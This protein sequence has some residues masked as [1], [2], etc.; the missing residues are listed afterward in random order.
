MGKSWGQSG[1]ENRF[2]IG[3]YGYGRPSSGINNL[4]VKCENNTYTFNTT[5]YDVQPSG[6][7]YHEHFNVIP[8]QFTFNTQCGATTIAYLRGAMDT[9]GTA[10]F[11]LSCGINIYCEFSVEGPAII[12][13]ITFVEN[14]KEINVN[15][16]CP[17]AII[18]IDI[19]DHGV[20]SGFDIECKNT[21][22]NWTKISSGERGEYSVSFNVSDLQAIGI[23]PFQ[24]FSIRTKRRLVPNNDYSTST[25][26][27]A[28][29]Y[30]PQFSFPAGKE[31]I[32]EPTKCQNGKTTIKIPYEGS[33]NYTI[34]IINNSNGT[35]EL[36][37]TT[38]SLTTETINGTKYYV[39]NATLLS[40]EHTLKIE[41]TTNGCYFETTFKVTEA[42]PFVIN[43]FT[44]PDKTG[45]YEI[46]TS[47][48]KGKVTF[49]IS[50]S[51][52]QNITIKAGTESFSKT[53]S[54]STET[55]GRTYYR[56]SVTIELPA[57]TYNI[58]A[59]NTAGCTSNTQQNVVLR[60]PNAI[61]FGITTSTPKCYDEKGNVT[62]KNI[63]GGIGA[64]TY[65]IGNGEAQ[66]FNTATVEINDLSPGT[67]SITIEDGYQNTKTENF[68]IASAPST[69]T[70]TTVITA[71][72]IFG[73]TDGKITLTA[74]GGTTPYT[75]SKNN[76]SGYQ[77]SNVLT[78]FS[79]GSKTVFVK[80]AN[81]CV[82]PFNTTIPEGRQ[83]TIISTTPTAPAC[84]GGTDGS[85]TL[86]IGNPK[87]TL[88]VAANY[89]LEYTVNGNSI[90]FRNLQ[91]DTYT[92]TITETYNGQQ[93]SIS[94][95]FTIPEKPI[96]STI[97]TVTPVSNKGTASGKI[98][99]SVSGGNAG[100]YRVELYE[101]NTKLR[102]Q[103][104][105][106]ACTFEN[107]TGEAVNGGKLYTLKIYDSRDCFDTKEVRILEPET[108]LI[109][110]ADIASPI[111]C[112]NA[113][114]AQIKITATGGWNGFLYSADSTVWNT[115]TTFGNLPAGIYK[116]FV[117]DKNGGTA[118]ATL[119]V[120]NP[121]PLLVETNTVK[122]AL[123]YGSATGAL[124]FKVSGG[125]YPYTLTPSTG[126][127]TE[128]ITASDTLITINDLPANNYTFTVRDSKNCST[129]ATQETITQPTKLELPTPR[130]IHTTCESPNGI[131]KVLAS[132]G[133][134]SYT[135]ILS[136][137][138]DPLFIPPLPQVSNALDTVSF[139]NLAAGVYQIKVTDNNACSTL[140]ADLI[141]NTYTN[142]SISGVTVDSVK[143]FGES[144][145]R[146]KVT[147]VNTSTQSIQTYFLYNNDN[148]L[149]Q[150]NSAG[151]F[152]NLPAGNYKIYA[153]DTNGCRSNTA[154]PVTVFEPQALSLTL[155]A[156][157]PVSDKGSATGTISV[158][159][160]GGNA[161]NYTLSLYE[162]G[163]ITALQSQAGV[164]AHTFTGLTG[165]AAG[166][167][168]AIKVTD[169]KGCESAATAQVFEPD[170][171]LQLFASLTTPVYCYG[172]STAEVTLDAV[173]GWND[174]YQY[175][176]NQQNWVNSPIFSGLHAGSNTFTVKDKNGGIAQMPFTITEPAL[177]RLTVSD[178][179]HTTCELDNGSLKAQAAGG[180]TPYTYDLAV[181]GQENLILQTLTLA[182]EDAAV[183][184]S[185]PAASYR[186]TV[187]DANN[188]SAPSGA[189]TVNPYVN[190][191]VDGVEVRDVACFGE[192]NGRVVFTVAAGSAHSVQTY[193]LYNNAGYSESNTGGV[194]E[195][196][197]AGSY[198]VDVFDTN[199]CQS[200]SPYPVT[201]REP[202]IL[203]I[204]VDT[205]I[206][207]AA[208]GTNE[209]QI[210]FRIT[211]GNE[212]G[213]TVQ[214]LNSENAVVSGLSGINNRSLRFSVGA[215]SYRIAVTDALNC[216]FTSELLQVEEPAEA[217]HL[218]VQNAD[219][220]FCKSQTG[221]IT[222]QGVG[223]WGDYRYKRSVEH[224]YS[225]IHQYNNLYPGSYVITVTDGRGAT[226]SETIVINE[227]QDSLKA[228]MI[229]KR[230]P[231]CGNNGRLSIRL[232]GGTPPYKLYN[233]AKTDSIA[234][235]GPQT[236]EWPGL[237]TGNHLFYLFDANGCRFDLETILPDTALLRIKRLEVTYPSLPNT[238]DASIEADVHG[239]VAP[240]TYHWKKNFTTD[241]VNNATLLS[242]L[243][244]GY[245]SLKVTDA[246]G[247]SVEQHLYLN[248]P[249]DGQL[250]LVEINHETSLT[251]ANGSAVLTA[252]NTEILTQYELVSP[253]QTV[254]NYSATDVGNQFIIRN[255]S[256]FLSNLESGQWF[257]SGVDADGKRSVAE[258]NIR[259][260]PA[261]SFA[262]THVNHVSQPGG[263]NGTIQ[264]DV[265]GGGGNNQFTWTNTTTGQTVTS[266]DDEQ[267]SRIFN[268]PAGIYSVQVVD[269]YTNL[270]TQNVEMEEP[271]EALT[272]NV[273]ER[274]DQSCKDNRDAYVM[275]SA[276]G[277][278][279]DYQFRSHAQPYFNNN[280][281][282]S[283]LPTGEH[284]FYV[285]DKSGTIDSIKVTVA[286]P[287]YLQA[288]IAR[289][290][291]VTCKGSADGKV[292]FTITG[293]TA[294]YFFMNTELNIWQPG[295]E[296]GGL[297]AGSYTFIFKD[298]H[299]CQGQETVIVS[300]PEPDSLL[301]ENI[302]AT[303]TTC[304]E[305]NGQ[306]VV[307]LKGGT[308][309]YTYR[310]VDAANTEI[311]TDSLLT[312]LRQNGRYRLYVTDAKGCTQ[313]FEQQINPSTLP[314]IL[315]VAT[316]DV[317]CYGESNATARVTQLQ[318][319]TPFSP[320]TLTWSNGDTGESSNHFPAG[321]HSVTISDENA[322]S[323]TYYFNIEQ[324]DS[325]ILTLSEVREPLCF[326]NSDG[327]IHTTT[328]GGTAP[329]S[330]LWSTNE[331][332]SDV[333]NLSKGD[334]WVIVTDK[335]G[336]SYKKQITLNE[337]EP[338]VL[339][340]SESKEPSCF[341]SRDGYIRTETAGG[342]APYSYKW[343]TNEITQDIN[344]LPK[345]D[346]WV[347][348]TDKNDCSY[349]T[350][351]TLNEPE[352]LVL[353][354]SEIQEP[355]C[356]GSNDGYI[357]TQTVGGTTDYTY[358]WSTG[359]T[360][361][362]ID[363][364]PKGA[365]W[366]RVTDKNACSYQAQITLN[367]PNPLI[368]TFSEVREPL[369]SGSND[370]YIR[371]QTVGG[372][373]D[374]TYLWS[375]GATTATIDNVSKGTYWVRVTD[376]NACSYQTQITLNEPE[377][378][379]LS[380][381]DVKEPQCFG[382]HN[383]SISTIT[384]GGTKDY[385]YLWSTG[386]TTANIDNVPKG[387]YWVRVTDK[388]GCSYQNQITLNEPEYQTVDLGADILMCP[389][390][391]VVIDGHNYAAY[392]WFTETKSVISNERYLTVKEEGHY[393]LEATNSTGCSV[394]GDVSVAIGNNALVADL[395]L[396]S[397]SFLGDSLVIFE[398]S[399]MVLDS[400]I[401]D[402]DVTAFEVLQPGEAYKELTY[403]LSLRSLQT[404][405][406]NIKLLAYAG[407]CISPAIKQVEIVIGEAG[408]PDENWGHIEPL[409]KAVT[410]YPNPSKGIFTVDIS[411]R[412]KSDVKLALFEVSSGVCIN[413]RTET[414]ADE[415]KLNYNLQTL[416]SGVYTLIITAGNERKQ[417]KLII[418]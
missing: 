412:E 25:F 375:T 415:Y 201:V 296:A 134:A 245:Y 303:H 418:E 219:D 416:N 205:I 52:N 212:G 38:S 51:Y 102:E 167:T 241:M 399:N 417:V 74:S 171:V 335:N 384:V 30:L 145:G 402:Y 232:S 166:K 146:I 54:N 106:N 321:Q 369:C 169:V 7:Y 94:E 322:C 238:A 2:V 197:F 380:F 118:S 306:I 125:T 226:H 220:A 372:T 34:N 349:Q 153:E 148:T 409:L 263:S 127:I 237:E 291:S 15:Y 117:K 407:G 260:Y 85:C 239:G 285:V 351:I 100:L 346:Y 192:N 73:N 203:K 75:Y 304:N 247:C 342:T 111:S 183:F 50:G 397:E 27:K 374:Y 251:A 154:Y 115:A 124:V 164:S 186:I 314:S 211:G 387:N 337:P 246:A 40:G 194:F 277:G 95:T 10:G 385:T 330:Y 359:A 6:Y 59:E 200:N 112:H 386:A 259:P 408:D 99:V 110:A 271:A 180:A 377:P 414:G 261:F 267:S 331:I 119:T 315:N 190:P 161:G 411:L 121:A 42:P 103:S 173:G 135:Y 231:T 84:N 19:E 309:P 132:G 133:V 236:V 204:T 312:G 5:F 273:S 60:Q 345:G 155:V 162:Q 46:R 341:G 358:L 71:P 392:R 363:N 229:A 86:L 280:P 357:R 406:F 104:A 147:G 122:P 158:N 187:T 274:Q 108:A 116:Y 165:T 144:N 137:N 92:C 81:G 90:V 77:S 189:L 240:Y 361:A 44:F 404:G 282:H 378:L 290:D 250:V 313:Y 120:A 138:D 268:V 352:P 114:D 336:Y 298:S 368:L 31:L 258:W 294:P 9:A 311:G 332:T 257:L 159:V 168:Y 207:V 360:T 43:N 76:D 82:F 131:V 80:D 288:A 35:N 16:A 96:I 113:N 376:K 22:G 221:N 262:A 160:S 32:V 36:N 382:Y 410:T 394:W 209:G 371:T 57:G 152:D 61:N 23:N 78:G 140:S 136:K 49:D 79:S 14:K 215:G 130:I 328:V 297:L 72:S 253:Q 195:N 264:V 265:Q 301:F 339:N 176:I 305:D 278:W 123:C 45:N 391:S 216:A 256:V 33:T 89:P 225:S 199:G 55:N 142:P 283:G 12:K 109:L 281:I 217:L 334:Y 393:F 279:G 272:I 179:I 139:T 150:S 13:N 370:G 188:C 83:I 65:K 101:G 151:D 381:S 93:Y 37:T 149:N 8:I 308:R 17:D 323:S 224:Q 235:E 287:E 327:Y 320:Y 62:I 340:F 170:L 198:L 254:K 324:P 276:K 270:L 126:T 128:T 299:D 395:L 252:G 413:Q 39:A 344:N 338:L 47:G 348:V 228:E 396:P 249:G 326:G 244:F 343:S 41:P 350:Q 191:A 403:H 48:G 21:S 178:T 234:V 286:E 293:G 389:G 266:T 223:G 214:L 196:L 329:Y 105:G 70:V 366:V 175:R 347:I 172:E 181:M 67:Y 107:L 388:N 177:L 18:K 354:F 64:Y 405:I 302:K 182:A 222:V 58:S 4:V 26:T 227:P 310:W 364:L 269:C 156:V 307:Q 68:A 29:R 289:V 88:S 353:T 202:Q 210:V 157:T 365:Y 230:L 143:C 184:N 398:L 383:A 97:A 243:T 318:P 66:S 185:L 284:A 292:R 1:E 255:D 300:I 56:G 400:L 379:I 28:F 208:K 325:L 319:A 20:Y 91:V 401:W 163:A 63:T 333:N 362:N 218:I 390:N 129:T 248:D 316:T 11:S 355:L 3:F 242:N 24:E 317:L 53:L 87:G 69:V 233:Q 373:T 295:N 98:N 174:D 367:E 275:L 206:A 213:K 141:I 193:T 356:F